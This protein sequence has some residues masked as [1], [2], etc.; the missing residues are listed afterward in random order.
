MIL[1]KTLS[2]F[3]F[4]MSDKNNY[5]NRHDDYD[6]GHSTFDSSS[7]NGQGNMM[8]HMTTENADRNWDSK[9]AIENEIVDMLEKWPRSM[10]KNASLYRKSLATKG[11]S[12]IKKEDM[13]NGIADSICTS[14]NDHIVGKQ[15]VTDKLSRA[16][17]AAKITTDS[18]NQTIFKS[19]INI[20]RWD[21]IKGE[22]ERP[23]IPIETL[24]STVSSLVIRAVEAA[25]SIISAAITGYDGN[26]MDVV[27]IASLRSQGILGLVVC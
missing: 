24:R 11:Y 9:G 26:V 18:N 7:I 20:N 14:T 27:Y 17:S 21:A 25:F 3:L 1:M 5:I 16:F 10:W 22:D 12:I 4:L 6:Y 2:L 8:V 15:C 13:I 23:Y 19:S